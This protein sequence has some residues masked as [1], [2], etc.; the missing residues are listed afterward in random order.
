M[1]S[2]ILTVSNLTLRMP[3]GGSSAQVVNDVSFT[4]HAGEI[5]CLVGESGSGK[6]LTAQSLLCLLDKAQYSEASRIELGGQ[7][8]LSLSEHALRDIRGKKIAMIFQEPMT[9]LNPVLS[10]GYQITEVMKT[11]GIKSKTLPEKL[12]KEVGM[13]DPARVL[14]LYPHQLSGGM[15]QRVMIAMALATGPDI[16]IADEPTTALDVTIQ[17]QVL[18]IIKNLTLSRDLAIL[19]ITHDLSIVSQVAD[20]VAVMKSGQLVEVAS[21]DQFFAHPVHEYSRKLLASVPRLQAQESPTSHLPILKVSDLQVYYPIIKG[22]F[23]RKIGEVRAVDGISFELYKGETL[24]IVGESGSGK[25]STAQALL[26]LNDE[27]KGTVLFDS[28]NLLEL[29]EKKLRPLRRYIQMIFQDPMGSLNPRMRVQDILSEGW[30]A[31]KIFLNQNKRLRELKHLLDSVGLPHDSLNRYPHEFSGGQ[32]QRIAIARALALQAKI[33]VCDEPTSALD[34][35]VQAQI[36]T[37]LKKIQ[38]ERKISYI[39]ISHNIPVVSSLAH[40]IAVMVQGKIVEIGAARDIIE[41]PQ[42][43]YTKALLAAVP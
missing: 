31:Q 39:F 42:H 3:R 19:F 26:R 29:N 24:A 8:L 10:I 6:T 25:S 36:L 12:L 5:L 32:H 11:H 2:G 15:R 20:T 21:R 16:L 40:R 38:A 4:L 7:D 30:D 27:A 33:I 1:K 35:S 14:T 13:S 9:S 23:N 37:L 34:V 17:A 28:Q 41:N 22:L 18:S 43:P